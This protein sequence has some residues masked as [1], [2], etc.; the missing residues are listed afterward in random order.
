MDV[1]CIHYEVKMIAVILNNYYLYR[2]I[3]I[4][5]KILQIFA[6]NMI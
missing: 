3:I 5:L 4:T 6:P 2:G 1:H